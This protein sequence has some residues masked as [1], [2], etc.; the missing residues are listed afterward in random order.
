MMGVAFIYIFIYTC[1]YRLNVLQLYCYGTHLTISSNLASCNTSCNHVQFF[2]LG[3]Y[4]VKRVTGNWI[5]R[6]T[7]CGGPT[8]VATSLTLVPTF[9]LWTDGQQNRSLSYGCWEF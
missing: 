2:C 5:F 4:A 3:C 8:G 9:M 6:S 1:I 7:A